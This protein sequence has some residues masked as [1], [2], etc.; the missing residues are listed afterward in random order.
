VYAAYVVVGR[1]FDGDNLADK[2]I[3]HMAEH[4]PQA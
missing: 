2:K 4:L 3:V 1:W